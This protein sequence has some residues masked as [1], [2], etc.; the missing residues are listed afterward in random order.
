LRD[1]GVLAARGQFGGE[2]FTYVTHQLEAVGCAKFP[3]LGV[4]DAPYIAPDGFHCAPPSL[5][6]AGFCPQRVCRRRVPG[7]SVY[8][9]GDMADRHLRIRPAWEQA[10]EDA[11]ADNGVQAAD[12]VDRA[13]PTDGKIGHA[14]RFIRIVR[15]LA[16]QREQTGKIDLELFPRVSREVAADQAGGE[17]IEAGGDGSVSREEVADARCVEADVE[18]HTILRH[19]AAGA[20]EHDERG[21]PLIEMADLRLD[22]ETLKEAPAT[23]PEHQFLCQAQLGAATIEFAR[24]SAIGRLVRRVIAVEQIQFQPADLCFPGAQPE[25]A[26]RQVDAKTQP[27]PIRVADWR[28]R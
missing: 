26:P 17:A 27:F 18:R 19:E 24:N 23:E 10:L 16:A 8:P 11:A 5:V 12:S 9:V 15:V 6:A 21:M 25:F 1:R 13:A 28:Y 7:R 22:P 20:F 4:G 2:P 3:Q 14:E